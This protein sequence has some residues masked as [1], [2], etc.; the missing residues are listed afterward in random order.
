MTGVQ[1]CAL[2]IWHRYAP[3]VTHNREHVFGLRV[4]GRVPVTL[5]PREHLQH[6]W[7]PI[8]KAAAMCFSATN[9]EAI[10][11]LMAKSS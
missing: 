10:L 5:A 7:L 8:D 4:T 1:T 6:V 2:P 3:G 9:R 11:S